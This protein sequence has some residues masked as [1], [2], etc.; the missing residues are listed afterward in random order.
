LALLGCYS[1]PAHVGVHHPELP[2][3]IEIPALLEAIRAEFPDAE[4]THASG[5]HVSEPGIAG[6]AQALDLAAHADVVETAMP[7]HALERLARRA[8]E[9]GRR[10]ETLI[11]V[12]FTGGRAGVAPGDVVTAADE[13]GALEGLDLRGL[14]TVAPITADPE[15]ARPWFRRLRE[16]GERVRDRHPEASELS[17]GMSADYEV[18]LREG[19]TMVRLGTAL[20]GARPAR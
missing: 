10:L 12:D 6:F 14:M 3:G 5:C 11:E 18:A 1:F 15:V 13:V 7:G 16:L 4:V 17:M 9:E 8:A 2:L 19:A 20:F